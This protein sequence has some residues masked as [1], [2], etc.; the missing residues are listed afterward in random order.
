VVICSDVLK[1]LSNALAAVRS[2]LLC[3]AS[4]NLT[5]L[6]MLLVLRMA[7]E[8]LPTLEVIRWYLFG[9]LQVAKTSVQ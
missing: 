4:F 1:A 7:L 9:M 8:I 3:A 2:P 6:L 5:G